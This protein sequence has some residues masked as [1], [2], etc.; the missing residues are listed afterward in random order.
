MK[1]SLIYRGWKRTILSTL[2]KHISP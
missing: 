1:S 2:E